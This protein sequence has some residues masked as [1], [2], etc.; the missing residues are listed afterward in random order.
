M[1]EVLAMAIKQ[2]KR[3]KIYQIAKEKNPIA[4]YNVD[5]QKSITF[6]HSNNEHAETKIKNKI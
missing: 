3:N 5:I 2:K 1:R 4:E 6:L